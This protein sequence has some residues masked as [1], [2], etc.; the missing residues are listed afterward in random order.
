MITSSDN[1]I[2][3]FIK[4]D[5]LGELFPA[6]GDEDLLLGDDSCVPSPFF[7]CY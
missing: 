4:E 2:S 6:S 3:A 7:D 5:L 1:F